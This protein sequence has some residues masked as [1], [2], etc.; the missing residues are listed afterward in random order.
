MNATDAFS[1]A[2]ATLRATVDFAGARSAGDPNDEGLH[3]RR[4]SDGCW[5][6]QVR[7]RSARKVTIQYRGRRGL[8][9]AKGAE[10]AKALKAL[11]ALAGA[12]Q[13]AQRAKGAERLERAAHRRAPLS[14]HRLAPARSRLRACATRAA[15]RRWLAGVR[16]RR[17]GHDGRPRLAARLGLLRQRRRHDPRAHARSDDRRFAARRA[18][19]AASILVDAGDLLQGNPLAY[20]AARVSTRF[21]ESRSSRR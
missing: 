6:R 4:R 12:Y 2:S 15:G 13:G 1:S 18:S 9:G 17:R 21:A 8:Q 19:G 16:A 10:G 14:M 7:M 3:R 5:P 11:R 20:V